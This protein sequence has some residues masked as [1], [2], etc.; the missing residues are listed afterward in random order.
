MKLIVAGSAFSAYSGPR[1][2]AFVPSAV[3]CQ[4]IASPTIT[5][6]TT[7][8]MTVSWNIAY[9]KND[10]P[11][12]STSRLYAAKCLRFSSR[13]LTGR[14]LS[15]AP[16]DGLHEAL[17]RGRLV[18]LVHLLRLRAPRRVRHAE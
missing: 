8:L 5:D 15:V 9:G 10:F 16:R 18:V 12:F 3:S 2:P 4:T 1:M 7:R 11:R 13:V 6:T 17:A 14:S